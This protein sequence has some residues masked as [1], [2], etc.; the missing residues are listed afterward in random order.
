[1]I[2]VFF[3]LIIALV[4]GLLVLVV[5]NS[6]TRNPRHGKASMSKVNEQI[7]KPAPRAG[8]LD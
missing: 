8:G 2:T 1:M 5:M 6:G 3:L 7:E 4:A